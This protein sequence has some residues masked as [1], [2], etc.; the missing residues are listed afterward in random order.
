MRDQT[1]K[2]ERSEYAR[3][4][5]LMTRYLALRDHSRHEL[6]IKLSRRF[7]GE[8]VAEVLAEADAHGWIPPDEVIAQRTAQVLQRKGKSHRYVEAY[9][10]KRRLPAPARD[11]EKELENART[12]VEKRFGD[13]RALSFEEKAKASRFLQYRGFEPRL[14]R[15]VF[16]AEP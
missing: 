2:T 6:N 1:N 7:T 12:L 4:L 3:A 8:T 5:D 10:R 16:H 13:P 11:D 14:I 15:K 9:L